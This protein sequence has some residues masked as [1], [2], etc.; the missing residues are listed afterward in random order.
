M[1][2]V[3][4]LIC[5]MLVVCDSGASHFVYFLRGGSVGQKHERKGYLN[6]TLINS[7]VYLCPISYFSKLNLASF[8][9]VCYYICV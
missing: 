6:H 7:Y 3:C 1:C 4:K 9:S 5:F 2:I 8:T